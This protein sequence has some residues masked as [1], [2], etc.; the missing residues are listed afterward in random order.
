MRNKKTYRILSAFMVMVLVTIAM[1][2]TALATAASV[3]LTVETVT[4]AP[5]NTVQVDITAAGDAEIGDGEFEIVYDS[6]K[7]EILSVEAGSALTSANPTINKSYLENTIKVAFATADTIT[8]TGN[9]LKVSFKI[10]NTITSNTT[11]G[12]SI[13]NIKMHDGEYSLIGSSCIDG[14]VNINNDKTVQFAANGG[15]AVTDMTVNYGLAINSSPTTTRS[16]YTFVGWYTNS[17]FTN[18]VTFPYTVTES[19]TMYAKWQSDATST[20]TPANEA[21]PYKITYDGNGNTAGSA[22]IDSKKYGQNEKATVLSQGTLVKTGYSFSG[23]SKNKSDALA[24]YSVNSTLI[25]GTENATLYA[26]W[27][28]S[29]AKTVENLINKLPDAPNANENKDDIIA[30]Y[31]MYMSLSQEEKDKLSKETVEKLKQDVQALI[32]SLLYDDKTKTL[33]EPLSTTVLDIETQLYVEIITDK[34]NDEQRSA[35]QKSIENIQKGQELVALY[36]ITLKVNSQEVEPNGDV[37]VRLYITDELKKYENLQVVYINDAGEIQV[38]SSTR[39]GD[40]LVFNTSH[41]SQYGIIGTTKDNYVPIIL[42]ALGG[43]ILISAFIIIM[44]TKK[45]NENEN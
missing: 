26:V 29:E 13:K 41:F 18:V 40:Y 32:T 30:A 1:V 22:P 16:G 4:G 36:N 44:K 3:G 5:N 12:I 11:A 42:I 45:R 21:K 35:Y 2:P 9:F 20:P 14:T 28:K 27:T 43:I 19:T 23:W 8:G 34:L 24:A 37:T 25:I 7:L 17:N 6:T 38:I 10:K 15:S 33:V 31:K 39:E